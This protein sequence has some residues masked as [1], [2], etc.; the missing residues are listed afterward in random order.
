MEKQKKGDI[1]MGKLTYD[2]QMFKDTFENEF[3]YLNGFLRNVHRFK[4]RK[5][6]TCPQRGRS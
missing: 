3:T 1:P 5:A 4:E 2:A 6:L